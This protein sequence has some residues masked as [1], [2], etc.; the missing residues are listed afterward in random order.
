MDS[1]QI[2]EINKWFRSKKRSWGT[3]KTGT[4]YELSSYDMQDF[5]DL[6]EKI[7]PDMCYMRMYFSHSGAYFFTEDLKN[8]RF[9]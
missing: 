9:C 5:Q 7:A 6:L 3:S 4:E 1:D 8:A 2:K